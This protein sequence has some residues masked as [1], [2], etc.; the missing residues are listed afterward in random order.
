MSNSQD[1]IDE[2]KKELLLRIC[3]EGIPRI[4]KCLDH[5]DEEELWLMQNSNVPSIANLILHLNGNVRQWFLDGFCGIDYTRIREK[6]FS[7]RKSHS[8]IE[9]LSILVKLKSDIQ[10]NIY[11]INFNNL[12]SIKTIQNHFEVS[13]FSAISHVIEH[14]S[15]H[16][17][18]I[19]T[20]TKFLI[21]KDLAYYGHLKL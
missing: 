2:I 13:G 11:K 6:E 9:L 17:G 5:L 21:N 12:L 1:L 15:Y 7:A 14:F 16:V 4:V 19:T 10:D 3:E 8:K 20:L 18:Q